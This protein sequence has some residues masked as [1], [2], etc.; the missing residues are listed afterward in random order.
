M[1]ARSDQKEK[2]MSKKEVFVV[3]RVWVVKANCPGDAARAAKPGKHEQV[4]IHRLTKA[5]RRERQTLKDKAGA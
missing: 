5:E 4:H 3:T 1:G 2:A